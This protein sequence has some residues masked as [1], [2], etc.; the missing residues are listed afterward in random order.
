MPCPS[1]C[2]RDTYGRMDIPMSVQE[3]IGLPP[4]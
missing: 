3:L 1:A 4:D 2:P